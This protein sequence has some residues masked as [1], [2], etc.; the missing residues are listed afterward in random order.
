MGALTATRGRP[1]LG[2]LA[3]ATLLALTWTWLQALAL[4]DNPEGA[5]VTGIPHIPASSTSHGHGHHG[6]GHGHGHENGS[7]L[8]SLPARP[9][10][11]LPITPLYHIGALF[12]SKDPEVYAQEFGAVIKS[13]NGEKNADLPVGDVNLTSTDY[14]NV[15][16]TLGILCDAVQH[17]NIT[18]FFVM[19]TQDIINILS[20]VTKYVGIP[21]IGYNT[22][23]RGFS[24]RVSFWAPFQNKDRLTDYRISHYKDKTVLRQSCLCNGIIILT[25]RR[26]CVEQTSVFSFVICTVNQAW[27]NEGFPTARIE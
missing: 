14:A 10:A 16:K 27:L 9:T 11:A 3:R 20:I 23:V 13:Y 8:E 26:L 19:G 15:R 5:N 1:L 25:R 22:E 21:V 4:P 12:E 24:V 2:H 6:H 18:V 17:H 7:V